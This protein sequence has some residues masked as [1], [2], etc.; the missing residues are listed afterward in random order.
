MSDATTQMVLI[1]SIT[2][3]VWAIHNIEE[4]MTKVSLRQNNIKI[5]T[6]KCKMEKETTNF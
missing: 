4:I 5:N 2:H 3:F 1:Y 6:G